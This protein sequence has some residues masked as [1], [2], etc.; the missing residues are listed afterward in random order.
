MK[1]V[2]PVIIMPR[3]LPFHSSG[4]SGLLLYSAKS[5]ISGMQPWVGILSHYLIIRHRLDE[6]RHDEA[7]FGK[8]A[9]V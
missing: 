7:S 3:N 4:N 9:F 6:I 1:S 2:K 8:S 5:K